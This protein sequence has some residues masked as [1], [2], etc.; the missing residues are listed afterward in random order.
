MNKI[1]NTQTFVIK[2]KRALGEIF[3]GIEQKNKYF[4]FDENGNQI[5]FA[6]EVNLK[7]FW[8]FFMKPMRPFEIQ[9]T[10][11]QEGVQLIIKRPFK[12]LFHECEIFL[13]DGQLLG[14][15]KWEFAMFRKKYAIYDNNNIE[16]LRLFG[17]I[18][19][20][21][22]FF[23]SKM[24]TEVG[25]L[26]KKWSGIVKEVFTDEDNFVLQL[27]EHIS[28]KEKQILLGAIFLIDFVYFE[29]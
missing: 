26:T 14:S 23:I 13:P 25:K 5:L 21:W 22:T 1:D 29:R 6:H 16:I 24:G 2:Q 10:D 7:L 15:I 8:R 28:L 27:T 4:I 3:I 11:E 18:F 17:P 9:L 19:K 12:F 20:P